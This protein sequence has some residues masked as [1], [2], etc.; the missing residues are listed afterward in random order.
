MLNKIIFSLMFSCLFAVGNK[1]K[2]E[3]SKVKYK[4]SSIDFLEKH[5]MSESFANNFYPLYESDKSFDRTDLFSRPMFKTTKMM[6]IKTGS[7]RKYILLYRRRG[8]FTKVVRSNI[9]FFFE[10]FV[11]SRNRYIFVT[12]KTIFT[13][14]GYA[15]LTWV[16]GC[17]LSNDWYRMKVLDQVG[18]LIEYLPHWKL[19][20]ELNERNYSFNFLEL[21]SRGMFQLTRA[22][23]EFLGS[24]LFLREIEERNVGAIVENGFARFKFRRMHLLRDDCKLEKVKGFESYLK[25]KV[26]Q[27]LDPTKDEKVKEYFS[28]GIALCA[29]ANVFGLLKLFEELV[30]FLRPGKNFS[31]NKCLLKEKDLSCP[32]EIHSVLQDNKKLRLGFIQILG[33]HHFKDNTNYIFYLLLSLDFFGK[34]INPNYIGFRWLSR[35]IAEQYKEWDPVEEV[36]RDPF[37]PTEILGVSKVLKPENG[38]DIA[39]QNPG[40]N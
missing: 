13:A 3:V 6:R 23:F 20:I 31:L 26:W 22:A 7:A 34:L 14:P 1:E 19:A 29:N 40:Q 18:Y 28:E 16:D 8:S 30:N 36:V 37:E 10:K 4:E 35:D 32:E 17:V 21:T 33:L 27:I 12:E 39:V 24:G 11:L 2:T 38:I 15:F 5:C 9:N 25:G